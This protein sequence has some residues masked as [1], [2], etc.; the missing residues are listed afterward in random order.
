MKIRQRL[1]ALTSVSLIA[2]S[3][4]VAQAQPAKLYPLRDC[5]KTPLFIA[6]GAQHAWVTVV[7]RAV[8]IQA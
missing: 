8:W 6:R 2:A 4:T 1:T 3:A 7:A 5:F